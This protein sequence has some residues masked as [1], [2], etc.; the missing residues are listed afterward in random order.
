MRIVTIALVVLIVGCSSPAPKPTIGRPKW[1]R[2]VMAPDGSQAHI[3]VCAN[4]ISRCYDRAA[5]VC[6]DGYSLLDKTGRVDVGSGTA[7]SM[8]GPFGSAIT[9][10]RQGRRTV[11]EMLL[12]CKGTSFI[13]EEEKAP[14]F[15]RPMSDE[16]CLRSIWCKQLGRCKSQN[17][18]CVRE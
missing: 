5:W 2:P 9:R 7:V 10:Y 12:R 6:P 4:R 11:H 3:V 14:D 18:K 8:R 16:E 15:N 1:T 17:G 13:S